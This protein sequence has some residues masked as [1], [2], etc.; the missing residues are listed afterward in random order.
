MS[1]GMTKRALQLGVLLLPLL[2]TACAME[3]GTGTESTATPPQDPNPSPWDPS[4]PRNPHGGTADQRPGAPG[5]AAPGV[6]ALSIVA[7]EDPQPAPWKGPD[8]QFT[9]S[10]SQDPN[11]SP[12]N[13]GGDPMNPHGGH[14]DEPPHDIVI[15]NPAI[16]HPN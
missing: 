7:N 9:A 14:T 16:H 3:T 8:T 5:A 13:P 11:P 6:H 12:W 15:N 1:T 4:N 2:A 10:P